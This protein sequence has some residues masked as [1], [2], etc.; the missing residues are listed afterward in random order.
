MLYDSKKKR[1]IK[2]NSSRKEEDARKKASE[3]AKYAARDRCA[4][5]R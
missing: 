3:L 4:Y 5:K 2:L 1:K